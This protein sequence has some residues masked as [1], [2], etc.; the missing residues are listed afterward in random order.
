MRNIFCGYNTQH[1]EI[2]QK[3]TQNPRGIHIIAGPFLTGKNKLINNIGKQL[4][5]QDWVVIQPDTILVDSDGKLLS[6]EQIWN[7]FLNSFES[8]NKDQEGKEK[9]ITCY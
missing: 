2:I 6:Y 5:R 7:S 1:Q 8:K 3:I 9:K 4:R